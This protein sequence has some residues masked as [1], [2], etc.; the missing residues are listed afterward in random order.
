MDFGYVPCQKFADFLIPK[1]A[2]HQFFLGSTLILPDYFLFGYELYY[3]HL[4]DNMWYKKQRMAK[5]MIN[6]IMDNCNCMIVWK[7]KPFSQKIDGDL[8]HKNNIPENSS[9]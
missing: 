6:T 4:N 3:N 9:Y 8:S 2:S 1:L 7:E 5:D